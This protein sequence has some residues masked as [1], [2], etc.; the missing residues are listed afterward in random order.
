MCQNCWHKYKTRYNKRFFL[1]QK[2]A[3]VKQR[4]TNK[5]R[6][7]HKRYHDKLDIEIEDFY[8]RFIKDE[9][10]NRLYIDWQESN[11]EYC[12]CPSVDRINPKLGYSIDN[13][14]FITH[15]QNSTK[16]QDKIPVKVY[17]LDGHFLGEFESLN[18]AVRYTGVEQSNAWKVLHK[19][20]RHTG[21]FVFKYA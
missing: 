12:K 13:I 17:N 2:Y 3:Q 4:C 8:N 1:R 15:S 20:R 9:Q 16:D 10:F 11:Y 19:K 7:D 21:G 6:L 18:S 14:Q 5:K